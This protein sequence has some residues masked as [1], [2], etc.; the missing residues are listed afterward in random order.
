MNV[1]LKKIFNFVKINTTVTHKHKPM[2]YGFYVLI[3]YNQIPLKFIKQF[4]IPQKPVIYRGKK[5]SKHFMLAIIA[6]AK[7]IYEL[8]K[9]NIP[10]NY[11]TEEEENQ[12]QKSKVCE[13]CS[14][15]FDM[16]NHAYKVRDHSHFTGKYRRALCLDCNF[17]AKNPS[18][19]PIYFHN[20]TYDSH[21]IVHELGCDETDIRVIPNSS[22]KYISFSK[23]I[24]GKFYIKFIDTFRFMSES[25][26]NLADNLSE[27]KSRF[28][29][30]LKFFPLEAI[31]LVTRKGVFPYEYVDNWQKLEELTLPPKS[32]FFNSLTD[33]EISEDDYVHA[34]TIWKKFNI[35]TLG[36]YSD[37]YLLTDILILAD[38]FENFRDLCLK[39]LNLDASYF[40]TAPG[41][42]FEGML[43]Y[44][45]VKLERIQN[46]EMFLMI[47]NGIR[48]GICQ[49][50]TRYAK[51]NLPNINGIHFNKEK[52]FTYLSYFD[53]VNLYGKSM[54]SDLP[55]KD[56]QWYNDLSLDVM[57]IDDDAEYGFIL[58]VD[59]NYPEE[60]HDKH[61]EFPFLPQNDY[62]PNSKVVKL[63]TTLST[64]KNYV[65]HYRNLKQAIA[66]GLNVIKIH[67]IIRFAQSK[68]MAPYVK[69][70]TQMRVKASNEF[71][72]QFWKLL[73]N[74]VFGKCME[75]VRK[76]LSMKLTSNEKIAYRYMSKPNFKDR[77]IYSNNLMAIHM[78]KD[79]I[80]FDKPIY[81]GFAILDISKIIMYNFHYNVMKKKYGEKISLLYTDTDSLIYSIKTNHFFDDLKNNFL[82]KFDTSNYPI[83]HAC[84]N[85]DHKNEPGFFKDE[86]K[87]QIMT[88]F[89]SL[90]PKL[91]AYVVGGE[92]YKKAKGAKKY[93]INKHLTVT[94][95]KTVLK[96][97][98]KQNPQNNNVQRFN[99][100][101]IQSKKH[102][103]Y[104][105]TVNKLVL[106][107][108][109]DKRIILKNGI[110]TLPYGHY[111]FN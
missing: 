94:H 29:E 104:S 47:E 111:K 83:G 67:R 63:L 2:S 8:Y 13:L 45:K 87:S 50:I 99:I 62:P 31:D 36:E 46:Y 56:F 43:K 84:F 6:V 58:E 48:G 86:L 76:R 1:F 60:L 79:S 68:W 54:L 51:A 74:S 89:I 103:V 77:T 93:I 78:H 69:L 55:Y 3:D 24:E 41:L 106:S 20:L 61:S 18:F 12:F 88:E 98:I 30:T 66:N 27:D 100:N 32:E 35:N 15:R 97:F 81:V 91:Y 39:T 70:C 108:N 40:M 59:V 57:S 95:Y 85:N 16:L 105:E 109:C 33:S 82:Q 37:F 5:A 96:N 7:K 64:K 9:I 80:K 72:R 28:K 110:N 75:N 73:V 38:V 107:A 65:V 11:L 17:S 42:A 71:E 22:E 23:Q 25:L 4:K 26:S 53:C 44:T 52:P 21:F 19:I 101:S 90:R 49:S 34:Q 102:K 10:I 92:E 14:K